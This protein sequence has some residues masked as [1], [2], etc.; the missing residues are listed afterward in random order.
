M[1][2]CSFASAGSLE[3]K[4]LMRSDRG[5]IGCHCERCPWKTSF[6]T[7]GEN[8]MVCHCI[9]ENEM[10]CHCERCAILLSWQIG[11]QDLRD[12]ACILEDEL[13]KAIQ[14]G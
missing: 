10:V 3:A 2:I 4:I 9:G 14:F 11:S 6:V 13:L 1:R 12:H 5:E 7:S 8:E